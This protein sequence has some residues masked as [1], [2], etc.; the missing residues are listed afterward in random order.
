MAKDEVP[1]DMERQSAW[2]LML[3]LY[4]FISFSMPQGIDW[5]IS[6]WTEKDVR[7]SNSLAV[8]IFEMICGRCSPPSLQ[9]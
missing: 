7:R 3:C 1:L 2:K 9:A 5:F 4:Q 8:V 6:G